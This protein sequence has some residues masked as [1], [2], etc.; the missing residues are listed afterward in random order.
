MLVSQRNCIGW[1]IKQNDKGSPYIMPSG[2]SLHLCTVCLIPDSHVFSAR[3]GF[4]L[5]LMKKLGMGGTLGSSDDREYQ[6]SHKSHAV[7][8]SGGEERN[9]RPNTETRSGGKEGEEGYTDQRTASGRGWE[10]RT[11]SC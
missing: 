3:E 8:S 7:V 11:E 9:V 6:R 5:S 10:D 4:H 1:A 2:F